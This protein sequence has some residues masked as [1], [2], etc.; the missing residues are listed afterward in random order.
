MSIENTVVGD[1]VLA[2][3]AK[4]KEMAATDHI[5]RFNRLFG[6]RGEIYAAIEASPG[7]I[8]ALSRLLEDHDPLIQLTVARHCKFKKIN[9]D[10]ALNT[11]QRLAERHDQIGHEAKSSLEVQLTE[12][13]HAVPPFVPPVFSFLPRPPGCNQTKAEEMITAALRSEQAQE[14]I[15]Q[16]I[17]QLL[18]PSI[19]IWPK[20]S[21]GSPI[22]SRFGGL[23]AVPP[24]WT[25]PFA[26][27]E[28]FVF[29]AQINCAEL[30]ELAQSHNL[31]DR[32]L[33]SFFGDHDEINGI[34]SNGGAVF[35]FEDANGLALT[36]LPMEEDEPLPTCDMDFYETYEL[37]HPFSDVITA[38]GFDRELRDSYFDLYKALAQF[39]FD[40]KQ[41]QDDISKLLG[42]PDLIQG[43]VEDHHNGLTRLLLQIGQYRDGTE[44]CGWGPGGLLYFLMRPDDLT[45]AMFDLAELMVQCT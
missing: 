9:L 40:E 27:E 35:Y 33:L 13:S 1:L 39:G 20:K 34:P 7:G 32:G 12:A 4:T 8:A 24:G 36:T 16:E 29:L 45:A 31:P 30:G 38:L 42:W 25:W 14:I 5:G 2:L 17:V 15:K 26:E 19:R 22:G 41:T 11:L 43:E 21:A 23:P 10:A 6:Q 37:P 3:I 18:R 28:P 44:L